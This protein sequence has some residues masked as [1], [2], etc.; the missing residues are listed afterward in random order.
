MY[1]RLFR[2]FLNYF[3]CFIV[4]PNLGLWVIFVQLSRFNLIK[5][6]LENI[7]LLNSIRRYILCQL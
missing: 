4:L 1:V 5:K 6:S 2:E 7:S 3:Y